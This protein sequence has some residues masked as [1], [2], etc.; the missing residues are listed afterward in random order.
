MALR[1]EEYSIVL[2]RML[3]SAD[4]GT[5]QVGRHRG[6]M[7]AEANGQLVDRHPVVVGGDQLRNHC[8]IQAM[9]YLPG[10][11][12][13]TLVGPVALSGRLAVPRGDQASGRVNRVG[14]SLCDLHLV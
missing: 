7:H 5:V 13:T 2:L 14:K 12:G 1:S 6:A 3:P 10:T 9:L 4:T 8:R 11:A